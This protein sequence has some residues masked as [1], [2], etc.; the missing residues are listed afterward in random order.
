MQFHQTHRI[1]HKYFGFLC[2]LLFISTILIFTSCDQ[3]FEPLQENNRYNFNISGYLDASADT[4]W[5]RV[6]TVRESIDEA[7]NPEG[8]HVTLEDLESG[9]TVMMN[10]SVFISRNV[11]NYWTTM[12]IK[13]E[14]TYRIT[15][16]SADEK[17]SRVTVTTP[18]ELPTIYVTTVP[19]KEGRIYIDNEVENVADIQSVWFVILNPGTENIRREY[20]FPIRHTLKFTYNFFGSYMA[21]ANWEE[22]RKRI[23]QSV[24][25]A[26]ISIVSRRFFVA[27][28]GPEWDD[29]L[30]TID[31]I[32]YFLD[33]TGSNVENGLGYVVGIN[34]G[35]FQQADCMAPDGSKHIPCEP[36]DPIW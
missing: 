10:D 19:T 28:G 12:D 34:S 26:E 13:N 24:G 31:D 27:L 3:T 1:R 29:S 15:V 6:G 5:I 20:R 8:I 23:E 35:W 18:K 4:Q 32:E 25:N 7:P 22:E 11:L 17:E 2:G 21:F 36:L 16:E 14:Q 30:S 33:G 9:E